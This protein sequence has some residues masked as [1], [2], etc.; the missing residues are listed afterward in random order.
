[1]ASSSRKVDT[2]HNAFKVA[3]DSVPAENQSMP[4]LLSRLRKEDLMMQWQQQSSSSHVSS[5]EDETGVKTR[6]YK[7]EKASVGTPLADKKRNLA[8]LK[9]N[10][11]FRKCGNMGY[12]AAECPTEKFHCSRAQKPRSSKDKRRSNAFMMLG[13]S[14]QS[15]TWYSDS[16]ASQ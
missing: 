14:T 11:K 3:W 10:S 2:K 16:G 1:M 5:S 13:A 12:W 7:S 15:A 4:M 6:A 8:E 9:K